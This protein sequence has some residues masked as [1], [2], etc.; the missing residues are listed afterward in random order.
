VFRIAQGQRP[1]HAALRT[2]WETHIGSQIGSRNV[3][4]SVREWI[5]D[6]FDDLLLLRRG[7][8][9]DAKEG[10]RHQAEPRCLD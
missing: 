6:E 9:I 8:L 1:A 3:V 10:W 5:N 7:A 2:L 4:R